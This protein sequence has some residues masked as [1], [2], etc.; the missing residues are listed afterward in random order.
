MKNVL[1]LDVDGV[2]NNEDE[3][4]HYGFDYI[5]P[6]KV[7]RVKQIIKAFNCHVVLSSMWRLKERDRLVVKE[8]IDFEDITPNCTN[9]IGDDYLTSL[10]TVKFCK[11]RRS[12][13]ISWI[14]DS[15]FEIQKCIVLDDLN[16]GLPFIQPVVCN[17]E[18]GI[19]EQ[20]VNNIIEYYTY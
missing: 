7:L 3:L 17:S 4:V 20:D 10:D 9:F 14:S 19:T 12:E 16:I 13:I 6:T 15:K 1:F 8:F 2:L 5:C 11:S 18:T